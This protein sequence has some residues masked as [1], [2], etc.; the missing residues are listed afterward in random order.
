MP[1][2]GGYGTGLKDFYQVGLWN[3]CE[4]TKDKGITACSKPIV[5]YWFNP[6][7]ILVDEM[8]NGQ[9]GESLLHK[10]GS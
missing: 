2:N 10:L 5:M 7:Q 8:L 4:G 9:N 6:V 3:F 1:K